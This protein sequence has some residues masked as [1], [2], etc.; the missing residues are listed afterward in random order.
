MVWA[1]DYITSDQLNNYLP[2][3][4]DGFDSFFVIWCTAVSR[5]VDDF[6][7]RQFGKV[8]VA[9]KR[10]YTPTWDR[11]ECKT[12]VEIDDIQDLTNFALEDNDGTAITD[13][14]FGPENAVQKGKVYTRL[15]LD[16]RYTSKIR[17]TGLWGWNTVP[18]SIPTAAYIQASRLSARQDSPFGIAGSPSEGSEIRLLAQLDPDFKTALKP[19]VRKWWVK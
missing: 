8:T 16:T 10:T 18:S 15:V 1:P 2:V 7:G 17:A 12:Y 5:N 9:E 6:C 14:D 3:T 11:N 19:Y 4:H 13:Y